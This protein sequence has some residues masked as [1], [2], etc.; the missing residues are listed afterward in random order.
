MDQLRGACGTQAP[1][2]E[3][4]VM[5]AIDRIREC[6]SQLKSVNMKIATELGAE[7]WGK[8]KESM[9]C[10]SWRKIMLIQEPKESKDQIEGQED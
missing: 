1:L 2:Q 4:I 10:K 7:S 3:E 6:C 9:L 5:K 8:I